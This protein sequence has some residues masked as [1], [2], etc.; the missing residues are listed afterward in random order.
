MTGGLAFRA[1]A[2]EQDHDQGGRRGEQQ[3]E[4]ERHRPLPA[5]R[6]ILGQEQGRVAL[7]ADGQV[8]GQGRRFARAGAVEGLEDEFGVAEAHAVA[9]R[10]HLLI[11]AKVVDVGAVGAAKVLENEGVVSVDRELRVHT[12]HRRID[13]RDR[14][15]LPATDQGNDLRDVVGPGRPPRRPR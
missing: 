13:D 9:E 4:Q 11:H 10:E 12:R 8:A 2:V 6:R 5:P 7:G 1:A 15:V 3:H 14:R